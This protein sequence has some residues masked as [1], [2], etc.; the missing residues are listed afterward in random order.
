MLEVNCPGCRKLLQVADTAMDRDSQ[1]PACATVFRPATNWRDPSTA[2]T[3]RAS[4][5]LEPHWSPKPDAD[6][7]QPSVYRSIVDPNPSNLR[8]AAAG[9]QRLC[10]FL[11]LCCYYVLA[12]VRRLVG[13][14]VRLKKGFF[15]A[16][17][18]PTQATL[19]EARRRRLSHYSEIEDLP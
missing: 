9:M 2:P 10:F 7:F 16:A 13:A 15:K 3:T 11:G 6:E 17:G 14:L 18:R 8:V 5:M 1:C 19:D 12:A 4:A